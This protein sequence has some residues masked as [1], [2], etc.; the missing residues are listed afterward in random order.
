MKRSMGVIELLISFLLLSILIAVGMRVSL[1]QME[2]YRL[3]K[4]TTLEKT[5]R[6]ANEAIDKIRNIK[7]Q[8]LEFEE[9]SI[10][11]FDE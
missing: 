7:E 6:Q 9:D 1:N 2:Q 10:N 11:S 5:K 4:A 3:E 8:R